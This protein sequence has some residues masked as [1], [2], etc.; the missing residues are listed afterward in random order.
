MNLGFPP[1][2]LQSAQHPGK[3]QRVRV[4]NGLGFL[5]LYRLPSKW[6]S[7]LALRLPNLKLATLLCASMCTSFPS[8]CEGNEMT[9]RTE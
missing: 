5:P 4:R 9:T 8:Y 1:S 7:L 2:M 3:C 6:H